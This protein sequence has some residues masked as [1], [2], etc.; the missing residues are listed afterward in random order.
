MNAPRLLRP[1]TR[2]VVMMATGASLYGVLSWLTNVV[3]MPSVSLVTVRPAVVIPI[4][5]G[6][7]WG[8]LVGFFTGLV[9]NLVG[10][11][12]TG[13]GFSPHWDLG[14][15]ILGALPG[16]ARLLGHR[17]RTPHGLGAL[18]V[19]TCLG[20]AAWMRRLTEPL[21][22]FAW[23]PGW[24][25]AEHV[26]WPLGLAVLVAVVWIAA[27]RRGAS[28]EAVLW[29]LVGIVGGIGTAALLDVPIHRMSFEASMVGQFV[30]AV[31][32]NTVALVVLLPPLE[33]AWRNALERAGR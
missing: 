5:F 28:A 6:Y 26:A 24:V 8:P 32:A 15:G 21:E 1:D 11:T 30:P 27:G 7:T 12:L 13:W 20:L 33:R 18:L 23:P 9:G 16:L 22:V 29:G 17:R 4:F 14:N 31:L 10:D 19:A 25:P 2:A 3:P